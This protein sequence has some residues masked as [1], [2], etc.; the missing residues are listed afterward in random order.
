MAKRCKKCEYGDCG[1]MCRFWRIWKKQVT[2]KY[3]SE[4]FVEE[5]KKEGVAKHN[6]LV[7]PTQ[8]KDYTKFKEISN[9]IF[10]TK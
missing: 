7:T 8:I 5:L 6:A 10:K 4:A 3:C 9:L 2:L 1:D